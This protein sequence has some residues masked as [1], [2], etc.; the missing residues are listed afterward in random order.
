MATV[1]SDPNPELVFYLADDPPPT[2]LEPAPRLRDVSVPETVSMRFA[3]DTVQSGSAADAAAS[4]WELGLEQLRQQRQAATV[5]PLWQTED[6]F[7]TAATAPEPVPQASASLSE[8]Q[9]QQV[10][11]QYLQQWQHSHNIEVADRLPEQPSADGRLLFVEDWVA[12]SEH[13]LQTAPVQAEQE[14]T[15]WLNPQVEA[16]AEAPLAGQN[17]P[18]PPDAAVRL[19]EPDLFGSAAQQAVTVQVVRPVV[20][21]EQPVLCLS[22]AALLA[23]LSQTLQPYLLDSLAGVLKTELHKHSV[24]MIQNLY[25]ALEAQIP[26]LVDEV[27]RDNL[28]RSLA[29]IKADSGGFGA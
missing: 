10:Y 9:V 16:E 29:Q 6:I 26:D 12:H 1:P 5:T 27:L 3:T 4:S 8:P 25:Q 28:Q 18:A 19:P 14:L 20:S 11:R 13:I 7:A 21:A 15:V 17:V 22:E 2:P 24:L 23:R